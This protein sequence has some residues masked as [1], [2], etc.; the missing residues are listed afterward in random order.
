MNFVNDGAGYGLVQWTFSGRKQTLLEYAKTK[1]ASIG[2]LGMQL[3]YLWSEIQKYTTVINTL[4][5][6]KSVREASD[7]VALRYEK[8]RDTS[9][10]AL[11]NRAN[12]GINYY[13]MFVDTG[14]K[15][16]IVTT[17]RVNIRAGNDKK[18]TR[19][20][21]VN[22]DAVFE[23]VATSENNWHAIVYKTQVAWISGE[24]S[25]IR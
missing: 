4:K 3:E 16:V 12:F 24:F 19:L 1:K 20:G 11:Q 18:Y 22:K 17:D 25:K 2:S 9:E 7:V 10:K 6:A 8:P 13:D 21:Q 5:S 15:Q 23:W 14:K